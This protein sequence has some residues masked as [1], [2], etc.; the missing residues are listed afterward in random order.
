MSRRD[1]IRADVL[2]NGFDPVRNTFVQS[3]GSDE[4]DASLLRL[5]AVGFLPA[6]D[7]R[8]T[9]TVAAVRRGL[10]VGD[11]LLLRYSARAQGAVDG[12]DETENAFLACSFWLADHLAAAGRHDEAGELFEGLVALG[13]DVG[14]LAE[15]YDPARRELTAN[16]PQALSHLALVDTALLLARQQVPSARAVPHR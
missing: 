2:A 8:M 7:P 16:F 13:N 1:Q 11:G 6:S 12:L 10:S 15:Q 4:L 5:P 14:L 3:Y 9:G